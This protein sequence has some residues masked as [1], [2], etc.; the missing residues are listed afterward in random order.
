[1]RKQIGG[2]FAIVIFMVMTLSASY[3]YFTE[4]ETS[5]DNTFIAGTM[6]LQI[7]N[8]WTASWVDDPNVP[9]ITVLDATYPDAVY[10]M[11]A[12]NVKPGDVGKIQFNVKNAGNVDGVADIH[13]HV[14]SSLEN[15]YEEPEPVDDADGDLCENMKITVW[16]GPE[17]DGDS[18]WQDPVG[19]EDIIYINDQYLSDIDCID[20][21][22]GALPAGAV[23][24]IHI[25]VTVP[26][27]VG[28]VIMGDSCTVD[29]DFSLDQ[30]I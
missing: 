20:Y 25:T 22:L 2:L 4:T 21:T 18:G 29:V 6:D 1:M 8:P 19:G 26:T 11:E 3:A 15:G 23:R 27:T 12:A 30:D 17:D 10:E 24:T 5:A 13:F 9:S 28:N 7:Y 14:T 16:Y